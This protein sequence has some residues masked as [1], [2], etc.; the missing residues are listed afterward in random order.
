MEVRPCQ[1]YDAAK[2]LFKDAIKPREAYEAEIL[3]REGII[4]TSERKMPFW[5]EIQELAKSGGNVD[6]VE[7]GDTCKRTNVDQQHQVDM[8]GNAGV[9]HEH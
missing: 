9:V 7:L 5:H 1:S 4:D 8:V 2:R 6:I 3:N